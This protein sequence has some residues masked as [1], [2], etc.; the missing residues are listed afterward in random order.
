M[1]IEKKSK[2]EY[3]LIKKGFWNLARTD[4]FFQ[5]LTKKAQIFNFELDDSPDTQNCLL[6][7]DKDIINVHFNLKR[8][9]TAKINFY[10]KLTV[11]KHK[12]AENAVFLQIKLEI[13]QALLP[14]KE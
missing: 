11:K 12:N 8:S 13:P 10:Q 5:K 4:L 2:I 6:E 7:N 1:K 14:F 9:V 3:S